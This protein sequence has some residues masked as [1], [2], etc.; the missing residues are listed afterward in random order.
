MNVTIYGYDELFDGFHF[1]RDQLKL[2]MI[3]FLF[4][5]SQAV[6]SSREKKK[7]NNLGTCLSCLTAG[8]HH[9]VA[10]KHEF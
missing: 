1:L 4:P 7:S 3:V 2:K 8:R 10:F 6:L 9:A 5:S